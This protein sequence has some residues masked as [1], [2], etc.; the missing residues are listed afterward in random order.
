M[1]S[2]E[3]SEGVTS[4]GD[5]AFEGCTSLIR[6]VIPKTVVELYNNSFRGWN[7]DLKFL[8]SRFIYKDKILLNNEKK[9]F[10]ACRNKNIKSYIIPEGL[11]SIGDSAFEGCSSLTSIE[12][13]ESVT[14]IDDSAFE[15][16]NFPSNLK[17][18]LKCRFGEN[19][20]EL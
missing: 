8:S 5:S 3:I 20:F 16:C 19:I 13:P 10:I 14:S 1:T 15:G 18:E 11:T 2:I 17:Q 6:I 7:G 4:I 12:I 9:E